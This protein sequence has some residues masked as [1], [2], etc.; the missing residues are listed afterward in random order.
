MNVFHFQVI[1]NWSKEVLNN[2]SLSY[3]PPFV[4]FR[5]KTGKTLNDDHK[6]LDISLQ[7]DNPEIFYKI[8][9]EYLKKHQDR[10]RSQAY[11]KWIVIWRDEE[12]GS[13]SDL[14]DAL[15]SGYDKWGIETPFYVKQIDEDLKLL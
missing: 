9:I 5:D 13:F 11:G 8:E 2:T 1:R 4:T 15:T 10:L 6:T 12:I 7:D 3:R 14:S